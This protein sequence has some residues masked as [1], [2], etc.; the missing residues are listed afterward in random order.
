MGIHAPAPGKPAEWAEAQN[1][2]HVIGY[3]AAIAEAL[4]ILAPGKGVGERMMSE[5]SWFGATDGAESYDGESLI[6]F[7]GRPSEN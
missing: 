1:A 5:V 3:N 6:F 4:E 2:E 7:E